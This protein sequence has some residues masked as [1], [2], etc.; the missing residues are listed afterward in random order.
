[1]GIGNT[2]QGFDNRQLCGLSATAELFMKHSKHKFC[3]IKLS[4]L[5]TMMLGN[6]HNTDFYTLHGNSDDAT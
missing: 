5:S 1:M 2:L 6:C 4:M 3:A